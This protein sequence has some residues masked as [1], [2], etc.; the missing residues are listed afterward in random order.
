M[1]QVDV[2]MDWRRWLLLVVFLGLTA[3]VFSRFTDF[4]GL[5]TTLSQGDWPWVVAGILLHAAYFL[6]NAK[7]Y[8][9]CFTTVGVESSAWQLLPVIFGAFF[10]NVV[11]PAG[12]A[13]GGALFVGDAIRRGQS[14]AR[15]AVGTV[16]VLLSDLSTLIPFILFGIVFLHLQNRLYAYDTITSAIFVLFILFLIAALVLAWWKPDVLR[17]VLGWVRRIV[18][19]IAARFKHPDL[20]G[21]DWADRNAEE[22]GTAAGAIVAHPR[23]LARALAW[24]FL[25]HVVNL[26][27]LYALFLA[28][29]Q[30]VQLGTLVAGFSMG[31]VFWVISIIPQGVAAVEGIMSLVFTSMGIPGEKT[32]AIV[33]AFRGV[34]F[35]LPLIFGFFLLR[36]V[37]RFAEGS[38]PS[39]AKEPITDSA[40][41]RQGAETEPQSAAQNEGSCV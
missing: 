18:N 11:V 27:G 14:G 19:R 6:M 24:A 36:Y 7:L 26:A 23:Q 4:K 17:R 3:W 1:N 20:L 5:V 15:A 21:E 32:A 10:I 22:L 12:G 40:R 30:T 37:T 29:R 28:F 8:Q 16:L 33:L 39:D 35:Y 9:L 34:N 25:M 41:A 2:R 31:I 38:K 13:A